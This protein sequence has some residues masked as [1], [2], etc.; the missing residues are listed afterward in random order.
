MSFFSVLNIYTLYT[1]ILSVFLMLLGLDFVK[2]VSF[3]MSGLATGGLAP[4]TDI[5]A[6]L[7]A[8]IGFV[9]SLTMLFGAMNINFHKKLLARKFRKLFDSELVVF[10]GI[11]IVSSFLLSLIQKINL[12]DSFFHIISGSSTT[13]FGYLNLANFNDNSKFLFIIIMFIGA[14]TSSTGGGI[15]VFRLIAFL[16]SIKWIMRRLL[17]YP[18][19]NFQVNNEDFGDG[20]ILILLYILLTIVLLT[21]SAFIFTLYGFSFIN[22]LFEVTSALG[23]VGYSV[24]IVSLS[25][26]ALPKWIL[27]LLMLIGRVEVIVFFTVFINLPIKNLRNAAMTVITKSQNVITSSIEFIKQIKKRVSYKLGL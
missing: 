17:G 1:V 7:N 8:P 6:I 13:G 12:A 15:K 25:L 3:T 24:G 18:V 23:C 16:K 26:P 22:S 9:I 11:I 21:S 19:V 10:L 14:C 2:S 5:S 4:V 27:S 20:I